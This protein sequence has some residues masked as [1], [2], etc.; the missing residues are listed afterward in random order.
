MY[1]EHFPH[2]TTK[3]L[4]ENI[5]NLAEKPTF[6]IFPLSNIFAIFSGKIRISL[7]V[8]RAERKRLRVDYQ[9]FL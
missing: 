6:I 2:K 1:L 9:I 8:L 3:M 4:T 7:G 5:S